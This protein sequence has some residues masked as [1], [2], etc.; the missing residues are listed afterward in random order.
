MIAIMGVMGIRMVSNWVAL[1]PPGDRTWFSMA[2]LSQEP[3]G[4]AM[5][6]PAARG[7]NDNSSCK[8]LRKRDADNF[9]SIGLFKV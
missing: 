7:Y 4:I 1:Y 6:T 9:Q 3:H 8:G 5:I 2:A